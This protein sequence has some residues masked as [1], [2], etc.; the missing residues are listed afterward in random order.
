MVL[1]NKGNFVMKYCMKELV[2]GCHNYILL[3]LEGREE[4]GQ[5]KYWDYLFFELATSSSQSHLTWEVIK[6]VYKLG[7]S[8]EQ[9]SDLA[10]GPFEEMLVSLKNVR[11]D[12]FSDDDLVLVRKLSVFLWKS[13]MSP[14]IVQW[15]STI[16]SEQ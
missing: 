13:R 4:S 8:D 15:I 1:G 14:E 10:V 7:L 3:P 11:P 2:E 6:E 16:R 12:F 5:F 9:V